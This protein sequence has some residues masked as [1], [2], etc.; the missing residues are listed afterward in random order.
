MYLLLRLTLKF[1]ERNWAVNSI[2]IPVLCCAY[3]SAEVFFLSVPWGGHHTNP[4]VSHK[5]H[6][7]ATDLEC[8]K[9]SYT[10]ISKG[11]INHLWLMKWMDKIKNHCFGSRRCVCICEWL[12]PKQYKYKQCN[13]A[14]I[15][16]SFLQIW[17]SPIQLIWKSVPKYLASRPNYCQMPHLEL[18][19]HIWKPVNGLIMKPHQSLSAKDI[20]QNIYRGG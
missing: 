6:H 14:L 20:Q 11:A 12:V 18:P 16:A 10:I 2:I 5:G 8:L 13:Q 19:F 17:I 3:F 1:G 15:N 7:V 4:R 9:I